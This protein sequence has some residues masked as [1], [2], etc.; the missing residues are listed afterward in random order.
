MNARVV[1]VAM[2]VLGVMAGVCVAESPDVTVE[3]QQGRGGYDG[4]TSV[5][6][7][8]TPMKGQPARVDFNKTTLTFASLKLVG[9]NPKVRSARLLL[10]FREESF[11]E[12]KTATLEIY[13]AAK[14]EREPLDTVK[15][16]QP[17]PDRISKDKRFVPWALPANLV[18]RW[19]DDPASNKGVFFLVKPDQQGRHQFFFNWTG[20]AEP[21]NR[22]ILEITYSFEG[23]APPNLPQL[24]TGIDGKTLGPV[25]TVTWD[26][27]RFDLRDL[28]CT[29]AIE[30]GSANSEDRWVR[31]ASVPAE[32]LKTD[33]ALFSPESAKELAC[34]EGKQYRLRMRA[35][36][37]KG[38]ASAYVLAKGSF[39]ATRQPLKVWPAKSV[40]K[41]QRE[42]AAPVQPMRTVVLAAPRNGH[43]SFQVVLSASGNL[44]N[45][46][47][48]VDDFAGPGGA[49]I[50]AA[51]CPLYRVHYVDCKDQGFLPD[52]LVPMIEPTTGKRI[53]GKYG[54][55]FELA[56]GF[57][58]PIWGEIHVPIDAVP[59][60]YRSAIRVGLQNAALSVPI[61]LTVYPVTLPKETTLLTYFELSQD[62]PE[63][64]YLHALHAH[65]IDVWELRRPGHSFERIDGKPVMTWNA[66]YDK[67]L[68]SY[69]DGSL[70]ADRVPGKTYLLRRG[71]VTDGGVK[72]PLLASDEDRIEVLKQYRA[73]YKDKAYAAKLAW[74]FIDEPKPEMLKKCIAVGRQIK[75]Y[76]P[77]LRFLLTTRFNKDLV[78][79]VDIWDPIIN[80]EVIDWNAP[81]PDAYRDEMAKG[82]TAINAI[83]VNCNTPTCPNLFIHHPGMNARIW[84][85][86]SFALDQQ[87]L[88]FW[89]TK[90]GP[91]VTEPKRYADAWGDGSL[92]YRGLPS[93]LD[94]AKEIPLPSIRLKILRDGI[95]DHEL[96]SLLK[97][98]DPQLASRLCRRMV[99]ETKEYDQSFEQ[100]IQHVSWNWNTDGKGDRQVPGFVV[101]EASPSR[102]A[103]TR[104]EILRIL[105]Q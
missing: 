91:S 105:S 93:E 29:Y 75:Q 6:L 41:V 55:P 16:A 65:R 3:V 103:A 43:E 21:V 46:D 81:G 78:G 72:D 12:I 40:V 37:S 47:P 67:L 1:V 86:V 85:W 34:Q 66:G 64:A 61:E 5:D 31:V 32:R 95:E 2:V 89:D 39:T 24:G 35:T 99:Q 42:Q 23:D 57:N 80:R 19:L 7:Y 48:V 36:N 56:G 25:F 33:I 62:T 59:G 38:L 44:S 27:I 98:K 104:A 26:K 90:P 71:A 82:R 10:H 94:V 52:S 101:W 79:L 9:R 14:K 30:L 51:N 11:T 60:I 28:A 96:L 102:L 18:Q 58:A 53:G 68:D 87:G 54:A 69:F 84:T 70:F 97:K 49:K 20:C 83:T 74:F 22:P 45:L 100:A 88:E 92:F 8:N 50:A 77:S 76:S 15:F 13:D 73:H 17:L 63:L 4:C